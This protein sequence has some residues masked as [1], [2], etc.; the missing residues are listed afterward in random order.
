MI[1]Q[2]R[3]LAPNYFLK[4]NLNMALRIH[5]KI[6]FNSSDDNL[7]KGYNGD[8]FLYENVVKKKVRTLNIDFPDCCPFGINRTNFTAQQN[9]LNFCFDFRAFGILEFRLFSLSI[10][11]FWD[12]AF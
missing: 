7:N 8:C 1:L 2:C 12:S 9:I 11:A 6:K 4:L 3:H 5:F 10:P